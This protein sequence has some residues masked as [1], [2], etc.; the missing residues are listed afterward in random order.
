MEVDRIDVNQLLGMAHSP[1]RNYVIPGVTSWLIGGQ[2][3]LGS[4]RMLECSRNHQEVVTPHSHRF[5]FQC[6]ILSGS[7]VNRV[8]TPT[9]DGDEFAKIGIQ[10][11]GSPGNYQRSCVEPSRY[12]HIDRRYSAGQVYAMKSYE[13]HSIFFSKGARVI[14]FEGPSITD[15]TV[16]LEPLVDGEVINTFQVSPWMFKK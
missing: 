4:V 9:P 12:A 6:L 10:Y 5:D 2:S 8:W 3:S 16:I 1:I 14:F 13:I 7:V 15:D 11:L